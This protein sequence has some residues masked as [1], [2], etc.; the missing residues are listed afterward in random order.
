[1]GIKY[2]LSF[3]NIFFAILCFGGPTLFL[4]FCLYFKFEDPKTQWPQKHHITKCVVRTQTV[5]SVLVFILIVFELLYSLLYIIPEVIN[6]YNEW[7]KNR[8]TN[9][10]LCDDPIYLTSLSAVVSGYFV[11]FMLLV[12]LGV[13]VANHYLNWV[14][15]K[16]D[17]G[18]IMRVIYA[19]LGRK[20]D[21]RGRQDEERLAL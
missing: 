11:I 8:G 6:N 20:D 17:P 21:L 4:L 16:K 13:F 18:V 15:D 10:T 19:C 2:S 1:M 12:V 3:F 7:Q 5:V 14:K 9:E